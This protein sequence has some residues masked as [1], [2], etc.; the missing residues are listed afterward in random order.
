MTRRVKFAVKVPP[1]EP[2]VPGPAAP[3]PVATPISPTLA[4]FMAIVDRVETVVDAETEALSHHVPFDMTELNH[5][6][7]QGVLELS[8]I[9]RTLTG[10]QPN[11]EARDRLARLAVKLERN[12]RVL[13]VK[14]RAVR[15]IADII[16]RSMRDAE[17]DGTYSLSA[18]SLSASRP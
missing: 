16:A 10:G 18:G 12:R 4:T 5:R 14:L 6:K 13:D 2:V 9:L 11:L 7:R 8:R 17:S 1:A 3:E 15:E